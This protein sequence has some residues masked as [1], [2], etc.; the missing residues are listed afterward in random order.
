MT[1]Y[2]EFNGIRS[3]SLGLRIY[4]DI[5]HES[6]GYDVETVVVP[7]RHGEL[8]LSNDR[9]KA[10][11]K[12]FPFRLLSEKNVPEQQIKISEWLNVEG[13]KP[14]LL[15]WEKDFEY[16]S[17][18]ISTFEIQEILR[19][20]GKLK[21]DLLVHPIKYYK[22]GL[23]MRSI[24]NGETLIGK[25]N[26]PAQPIVKFVGSGN[27]DLSI[28]GRL[29]KLKDIQGGITLDMQSNTIYYG[30]QGAWDKFVRSPES[31]KPYLDTGKNV[32]KWTGNFKV[33][34]A[35]HWGVK[36]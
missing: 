14:L 13:Y 23:Q 31:V 10:V 18:F 5:T 20:F 6:T 30:T 36:V 35:P 28:N 16:R 8:L 33:E 21:V 4:N 2:I 22:D 27:C 26:V 34:I 3:D 24:N 25:G 32:I 19:N 15:S 11:N 12:S 9:L 7:G 1:A 29:T 17:A